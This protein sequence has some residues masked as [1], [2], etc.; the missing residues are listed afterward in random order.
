MMTAGAVP[1][2]CCRFIVS[3]IDPVQESPYQAARVALHLTTMCVRVI[4]G[5][6]VNVSLFRGDYFI[7]EI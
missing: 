1:K 4:A 5:S 2:T 7:N 3:R 6:S